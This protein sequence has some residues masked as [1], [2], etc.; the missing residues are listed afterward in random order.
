M[1]RWL[2]LGAEIAV[3]LPVLY[4]CIVSI[5]ALL[6]ARQRRKKPIIFSPPYARFALLVPAHNEEAVIGKLLESLSELD[7]PADQYTVHIVADNCTDTTAEL[8]RASGYALVHERS[9]QEKRGKGFALS[10]LLEQLEK[11]QLT[12]DAYIVL[13][14]DSVVDPAFLQA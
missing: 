2:L 14:A 5:S 1:L 13:D 4:L 9:D 3:A 8:A 7:Y 11:D 12:Y 6:R 10:W